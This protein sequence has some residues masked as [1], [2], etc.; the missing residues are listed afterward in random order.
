MYLLPAR[1]PGLE[2]I[3][4]L[5]TEPRDG[6]RETRKARKSSKFGIPNATSL[7]EHKVLAS[8]SLLTSQQVRTE[9]DNA[10]VRNATEKQPCNSALGQTGVILVTSVSH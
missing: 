3:P 9:Q 1:A 2:E 5:A 4:A 7:D 8:R 10:N 6:A